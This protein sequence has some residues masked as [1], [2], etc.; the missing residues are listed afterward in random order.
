MQSNTKEIIESGDLEAYLLGDLSDK[1]AEKIRKYIHLY[2]EVKEAYVLLEKQ[3]ESYTK[4]YKKTP[5]KD[6]QSRIERQIHAM[7]RFTRFS[8]LAIGMS[9][10]IFMASAYYVVQENK[11]LAVKQGIVDSQIENLQLSFDSQL[12]ELRSQFILLN[13]PQTRTITLNQLLENQSLKIKAYINSKERMSYI[14]VLRLPQLPEGKC[15]ML[16]TERNGSKESVGILPDS[17][18]EHFF[19][20]I[21]FKEKATAYITIENK[22][23]NLNP[24][25]NAALFKI[26]IE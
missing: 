25:A 23:G 9:L 6:L 4:A 2:P 10:L 16:W 1:E 24:K 11:E 18:Q 14:E 17:I 3:L 22:P 15:Y 7:Q 26:P 20:P 21:P 8:W 19:I 13:S 5:S 12:N